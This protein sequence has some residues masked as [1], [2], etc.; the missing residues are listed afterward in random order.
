MRGSSY[1]MVKLCKDAEKDFNDNI[2]T[3]FMVEND[4]VETEE[5]EE[6]DE[7]DIKDE[8]WKQRK[9]RKPMKPILRQDLMNCRMEGGRQKHD[10]RCELAYGGNLLIRAHFTLPGVD[11]DG[12]IIVV[13]NDCRDRF[14]WLDDGFKFKGVWRRSIREGRETFELEHLSHLCEAIKLGKGADQWRW[15][16]NNKGCFSAASL[17]MALDDE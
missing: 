10:L 15:A 12:Y 11:V 14:V 6:A 7:T 17:R 2:E 3:S 1:D 13:A 4:D 16:L 8:L 9:K 5:E